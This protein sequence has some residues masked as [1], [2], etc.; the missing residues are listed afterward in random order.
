VPHPSIFKG[1]V[2]DFSALTRDVSLHP[3]DQY[4]LGRPLPLH[5]VT[6]YSKA[7][8]RD[9]QR[10]CVAL[11]S[12]ACIPISLSLSCRSTRRN[13]RSAAA[14]KPRRRFGIRRRARAVVLAMILGGGARRA[15]PFA[16]APARLSR[17]CP[18]PA[19]SLADAHVRASPRT[20]STENR[21]GLGLA[22]AFSR[23]SS[24]LEPTQ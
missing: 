22:P 2:F 10:V 19:R 6:S 17:D 3:N 8:L 20:R 18:F 11:D 14:K 9:E 24:A 23:S 13:R 16:S 1:A 7:S 5:S 21:A 4:G 15:K 12:C